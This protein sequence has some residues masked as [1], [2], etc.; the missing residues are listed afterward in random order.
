MG[1]SS[2][3]QSPPRRMLNASPAK[4]RRH[5]FGRPTA[6]RWCRTSAV[7]LQQLQRDKRQDRLQ[8]VHAPDLR[9]AGSSECPSL[10][11]DVSQRL[12][13]LERRRLTSPGKNRSLADAHPNVFPAIRHARSDRVIPRVAFF[14]NSKRPVDTDIAV[15]PTITVRIT[16]LQGLKPS[17]VFVDWVIGVDGEEG[18]VNG[19]GL[20]LCG[21]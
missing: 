7:L 18:R 11:R 5:P 14:A 9:L 10:R 13:S 20:M 19:P 21:R 2:R 8:P 17:V 16:C 6:H 15:T 1:S 12:L 4:R 3:Q